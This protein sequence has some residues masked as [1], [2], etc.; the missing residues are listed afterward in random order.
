MHTGFLSLYLPNI[1]F[2]FIF[3]QNM[4]CFPQI[5]EATDLY[6]RNVCSEKTE[7]ISWK[8][9]RFC[10]GHVLMITHMHYTFDMKLQWFSKPPSVLERQEQPSNHDCSDKLEKHRACFQPRTP[11]SRLRS[12]K[13]KKLTWCSGSV[14]L[15]TANL[16]C[17]QSGVLGNI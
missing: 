8:N 1:G 6:L 15:S 5:I 2:G 7:W 9:Q 13:K 12:L 14:V 17:P 3:L 11:N 4:A 16:F 10:L